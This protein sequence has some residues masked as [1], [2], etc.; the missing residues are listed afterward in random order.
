MVLRKYFRKIWW[1]SDNIECMTKFCELV[2]E[3]SH[4]NKYDAKVKLINLTQYDFT[5]ATSYVVH[6]MYD[7]S[8]PKVEQ[9]GD[10]I[11]YLID[12]YKETDDQAYWEMFWIPRITEL[13]KK[14]HVMT[15]K[16]YVEE[17]YPKLHPQVQKALIEE[18]KDFYNHY[19]DDIEIDEHGNAQV[20][21]EGL[22]L[23]DAIWNHGPLFCNN[24]IGYM[25]EKL[26]KKEIKL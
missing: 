7:E 26:Y 16:E 22:W 12:C 25:V 23:I 4:W 21:N 3:F 13:L 17:E 14:Y 10:F 9:I 18:V 20:P 8:E 5:D 6:S 1:E 11:D 2:E 24:T 15:L 19:K